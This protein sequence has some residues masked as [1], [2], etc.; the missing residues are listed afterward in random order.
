M[1]AWGLSGNNCDKGGEGG[2]PHDHGATMSFHLDQGKIWVVG[3]LRVEV[4]DIVTVEREEEGWKI[5]L[6]EHGFSQE[7]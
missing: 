2:V 6:E 4:A 1:E 3:V 7:N 5:T